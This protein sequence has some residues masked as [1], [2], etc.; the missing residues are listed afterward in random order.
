M[1]MKVCHDSSTQLLL[2]VG[3]A[4]VQSQASPREIY[5]VGSGTRRGFCLGT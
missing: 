3:R 2:C 5:R 1:Q 4:K